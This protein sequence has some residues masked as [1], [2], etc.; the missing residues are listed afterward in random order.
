M[1][2][3]KDL[4]VDLLRMVHMV[5]FMYLDYEEKIAREGWEK[6]RAKDDAPSTPS[7]EHSSCSS[8][9]HHSNEEINQSL[10]AEN[11]ELRR[12][13][14]EEKEEKKRLQLHL[15]VIEEALQE[16]KCNEGFTKPSSPIS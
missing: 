13:L 1:D 8:S 16:F 7:S 5:Y 15:R 11:V 12:L 4:Y 10:Q 9:S 2:N 3:K 6:E 14:Q